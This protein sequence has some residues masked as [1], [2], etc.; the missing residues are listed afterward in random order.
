L[1]TNN[2]FVIAEIALDCGFADQSHFTRVF[3]RAAGMSPGAW[4]R[5]YRR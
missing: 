2:N 1:L 3:Q 4:R 5:T